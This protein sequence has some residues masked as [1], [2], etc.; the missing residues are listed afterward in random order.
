MKSQARVVIVGG[1][2]M[3]VGLLYHLALEGWDDC[4]LLEKG[5][6]D[7]TLG[8]NLRT[9]CYIRLAMSPGCFTKNFGQRKANSRHLERRLSK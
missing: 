5:L 3:G 1:G 6:Y 9:Q 8:G 7:A 2:M 4:I